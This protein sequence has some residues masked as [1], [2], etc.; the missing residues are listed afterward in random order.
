MADRRNL[1][2]DFCGCEVERVRRVALDRDYD[3][4]GLRHA[5]RYACER[6]SRLKQAERQVSLDGGPGPA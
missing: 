6:C 5:V 3:R 1:K 2:C 4:L